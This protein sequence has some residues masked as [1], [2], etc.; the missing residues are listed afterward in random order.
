MM[1]AKLQELRRDVSGLALVEFGL[2]LP[3]LTL[4][5]MGGIESANLALVNLRVSQAAMQVADNA[6]RVRD[7]IDE[8]DVNDLLTGAKLAGEGIDLVGKGRIVLASVEDNS[9]TV[10]TN[11]QL[12]TWQRCKGVYNPGT[13][14]TSEGAVITGGVA[15]GTSTISPTPTNPIIF[16]EVYYNYTPMFPLLEG[17]LFQPRVIRYRSAFAIRDRTNQAMQNSNGLSGT[18]R[19]TC[20]NYNA[21]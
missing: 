6:A 11:D 2:S 7:R 9:A 3:F 19:A 8:T 18:A 1:F 16:V 5:T 17:V 13:T 15:N 20:N 4:A 21:T 14:P 10:A 12:V